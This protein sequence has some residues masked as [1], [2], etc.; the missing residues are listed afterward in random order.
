M[1]FSPTAPRRRGHPQSPPLDRSRRLSHDGVVAFLD[2]QF[3]HFT[4]VLPP[5][6]EFD[7][8]DERAR[9]GPKAGGRA[10][11]RSGGG[12]PFLPGVLLRGRGG[13]RWGAWSK[14]HAHRAPPPLERTP[15]NAAETPLLC[16]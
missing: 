5:G 11:P 1:A 6:S 16:P 8:G 4:V 12:G 15:P 2:G 7:G 13:G 9:V 10:P 14:P 3:D